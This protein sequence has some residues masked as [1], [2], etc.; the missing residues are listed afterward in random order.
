MQEL[1]SYVTPRRA[2]SS[3]RLHVHTFIMHVPGGKIGSPIRGLLHWM[4]KDG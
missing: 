1:R 3:Y 2:S 4:E